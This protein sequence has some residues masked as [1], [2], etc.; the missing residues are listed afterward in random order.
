MSDLT[1]RER[2]LQLELRLSN[3]EQGL[4]SIDKKITEILSDHEKRLR[5][6]ERFLAGIAI[7]WGLYKTFPF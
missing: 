5:L 4:L 1:D 7:S 6:M 2:L 3:L